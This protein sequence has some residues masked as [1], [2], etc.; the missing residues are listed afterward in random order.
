[1]FPRLTASIDKEEKGIGQ[2]LPLEAWTRDE[3]KGIKSGLVTKLV[4]IGECSQCMQI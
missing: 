2:D 1:M 3:P 4:V